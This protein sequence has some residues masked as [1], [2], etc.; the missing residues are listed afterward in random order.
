MANQEIK[1]VAH[2]E[3]LPDKIED[4]KAILV[5]IIEPSRNEAGCL[6]YDVFAEIEAPHKFTCIERWKD[7][8][9]LDTHLQSPHMQEAVKK[10]DELLA[11]PPD[12]RILKAVS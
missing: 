4:M 2:L 8:A 11:T 6:Q 7:Q 9:S 1:A 10:L 5:A 12:L 3:V